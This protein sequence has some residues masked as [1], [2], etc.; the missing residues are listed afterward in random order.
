MAKFAFNNS[1]N[2]FGFTPFRAVLGYDPQLVNINHNT[3]PS[4]LVAEVWLSK[5]EQVHQEIIDLLRK[6]KAQQAQRDNVDK[7]WKFQAGDQVLVDGRNL[8]IKEG[9]RKLSDC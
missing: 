1:V 4:S 3:E 2:R 8:T 7:A 6:D 5:M 9:T